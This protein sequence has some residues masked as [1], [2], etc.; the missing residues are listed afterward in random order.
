MDETKLKFQ[1]RMINAIERGEMFSLE[2]WTTYELHDLEFAAETWG[3]QKAQAE[4]LNELDRRDTAMRLDV[5]AA[6]DANHVRI[7]MLKAGYPQHASA[8]LGMRV[9][10]M[11]S[12]RKHA[13]QMGKVPRLLAQLQARSAA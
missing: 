4:I 10:S 12:A 2:N 1:Q 8:A 9:A 11:V 7:R 3:A 6:R 13:G 5:A